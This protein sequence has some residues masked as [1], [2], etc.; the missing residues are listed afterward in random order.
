MAKIKLV[1]ADDHALV[2]DGTRQLLERQPDLE[3]VG[4]AADGEEAV[5]LARELR[6]D[7]VVM[8]V[9]MPRLSGVEATRRIKAECPEVGVLVLT[10]HDDDEYVF[11]LLQAGAN[12]YLLKT[13]ETEQ[14]VRAIR[15]THAGQSALD[16]SVAKKVVTKFAS[17][18]SLPDVLAEVSAEFEGLTER[19][20][21][22]LQL[23]ASGKT[24]KEIGQALYISD[25]TVQAHLSNIFSKLG[26]VSRT[27][28]AMY[29][30]R[31]G[32]ITAG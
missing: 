22:V 17:G 15:A 6:P 28:A 13:A 14:L 9:R 4:E 19:E 27:E 25:R 31:K 32:W 23:V 24:N 5:R 1:L 20:L 29:A 30:V 2:R 26:V 3:V 7:L 10:A 11:A 21:E 18:K 12:G 16:P 8:D